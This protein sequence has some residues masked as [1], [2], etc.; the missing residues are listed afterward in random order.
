M[1]ERHRHRSRIQLRHV[2]EPRA[3]SPN[4]AAFLLSPRASYVTGTT[5]NLDGGLC[6]VVSRSPLARTDAAHAPKAIRRFPGD[7]D[8]LS[9]RFVRPGQVEFKGR[10]AR[11]VRTSLALLVRLH[12]CASALARVAAGAI[13][14]RGIGG[15]QR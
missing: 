14:R 2:G 12:W 5:I 15:R 6:P 11:A 7:T 9:H 3:S 1:L 8:Y 10:S 13:Q 4:L